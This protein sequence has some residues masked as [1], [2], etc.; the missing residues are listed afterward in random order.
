MINVQVFNH[1]AI[2]NKVLS[3]LVNNGID[4]TLIQEEEL[5]NIISEYINNLESSFFKCGYCDSTTPNSQS[6]WEIL[7]DDISF[8]I[9][10]SCYMAGIDSV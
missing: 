5:S 1:K 10:E 6:I 7:N 9:C 3:I 4:L 2:E 8:L